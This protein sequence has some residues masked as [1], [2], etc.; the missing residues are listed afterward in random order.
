MSGS[1]RSRISA[2][3]ASRPASAIAGA[4]G[5]RVRDMESSLAEIASSPS[6]RGAGRLRSAGCAARDQ[7]SPDAKAASSPRPRGKRSSNFLRC[8]GVSTSAASA[9]A[10]ATRLLKTSMVAICSAA[11]LF[12]RGAIDGRGG[13]QR[14][15]L[16]TRGERPSRASGRGRPPRLSRSLAAWPVA[17]RWRRSRSRDGAPCGRRA[18]GLSPGPMAPPIMGPPIMPPPCQGGPKPWLNDFVT[19]APNR[20]PA[21]ATIRM[22]NAARPRR[23]G[24]APDGPHWVARSCDSP[25]IGW[26]G[27]T[28]AIW[29]PAVAGAS[30]LRKVL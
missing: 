30:P 17:P 13:E 20:P 26:P 9:S 5:R 6:R 16:L 3:K 23:A 12:D 22:T 19:N 29:S 28:P 14:A 27:A 11:Q 15:R 24:S 7:F 4:A 21:S 1:I 10:C 25:S 2:S 18:R 8:S